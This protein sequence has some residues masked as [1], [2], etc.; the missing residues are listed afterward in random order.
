[1]TTTRVLHVLDDACHEAHAQLLAVLRSRSGGERSHVIACL[2]PATKQRLAAHLGDSIH[3]TPRRLLP[4][5][6]LAPAL[7]R[8]FAEARCDLVHAWSPRAACT[9]RAAV[10]DVPIILTL[11]DPQLAAVT[12][13]IVRTLDTPVSIVTGSQ[14]TRRRLIENGI[15]LE[16]TAVIRGPV[17]FGAINRARQADLRRRLVGDAGPVILLHGPAQRGQ[18]HF[19]G[20]WACAIVRQ[21]YRDMRIILPYASPERGRLQRFAQRMTHDRFAVLPDGSLTWPELASVADVF[22]VPAK[23]DVSIEPIA[24]AMGA[25]VLTVGC[26]VH[27]V[28]EVLADRQ[29]GLLCRDVS[30]QRLIDR[31]LTALED[32]MLVRQ[33]TDVARSQAFE[34]FGVRAFVDNYVRAYEN[35][36]ANVPI[37]EGVEDTAM[38]A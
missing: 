18:G 10:R 34:V 16:H 26:A 33:V 1:M 6:N 22:L 15:L 31:I 37:G 9:A 8:L 5:L 17:D 12:A 13:R 19:D 29:N 21:I 24:A 20:V 25:G 3:L 30:V 2:D 4:V 7:G 28:A 14:L 27:S 32:R 36:M 35:L 11:P 23:A 38:V